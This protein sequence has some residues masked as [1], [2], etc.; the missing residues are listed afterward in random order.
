MTIVAT[1]SPEEEVLA[2]EMRRRLEHA[3][4]TL[5]PRHREVVACRYLMDLSEEETSESLGIPRGTVKSR[6]S[7][8]LAHMSEVMREE[9]A[10][11]G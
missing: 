8:A 7:R 3:L 10:H 6:L 11:D 2:N 5:S 1:E 4:A 9:A